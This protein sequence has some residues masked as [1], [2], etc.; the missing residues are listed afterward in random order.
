MALSDFGALVRARRSEQG[1]S[2]GDVAGRVGVSKSYMSMLESGRRAPTEKQVAQLSLALELPEDVVRVAAGQFPPDVAGLVPERIAALTAALRQQQ[3]QAVTHFATTLPAELQALLAQS[4]QRPVRAVERPFSGNQTAGKNSQAY[5]TH[6][7]HTKVPP[8]AITRLLEHYTSPNDL[9]LDPFCGS[10]MTGVAAIRAGRHAL[11]SDLSPAAVHIARN[12][13]QP[14]AP[15]ALAAAFE[16]VAVAVRPMMAWLYET[17]TSAGARQRVEY[18]VWSDVFE[19][20][21]CKEHLLYWTA[22]RDAKT[23]AVRDTVRCERCGGEHEKRALRWVAERPVES[24]ISGGAGSGRRDVHPPTRAELELMERAASTPLVHWTPQVPFLAEREMWRAGHQALGVTTVAGFY[25]PRNLHALAT[26]RHTILQ[27][28]DERLRNALL[29]AFTAILNRASKRY[30]WNVKR[31]TN[32]MTGTLYISSL[33]YEWNVWSL[34]ERKAREVLRYYEFLGTPAGRCGTVL[35]SATA[36]AHVPSQSIDFVF[37]DPPFGSNI[38]YADSSLLWDAW[39]G[40]LTDDREEIVVNKHRAPD[41]GGKTLESYRGLMTSAFAE[42][43]RVLK[44]GA[45]ATLMFNNSDDAVWV[46]IQD[47]VREAGLSVEG[48]SGLDKVHPSIKGVKGRQEKEDVASYDALIALRARPAGKAGKKG[49]AADRD[50]LREL[51]EG[52]AAAAAPASVTTDQVFAHLVRTLLERQLSVEGVSMQDV[53]ALCAEWL[54]PAAGGW[55]PAKPMAAAAPAASKPYMPVASPYGCLAEEYVGEPAALLT[56]EGLTRRPKRAAGAFEGAVEGQRNTELYNAHSY[57]TKVPPESIVP[58]LEHFTR[59]G[60]VVLDPFSGSGMTG[61]AAALAGRRAILNDLSVIGAHLAFNHT[62]PCDADALTKAFEALY[63]RL[64]PRFEQLYGLPAAGKG[65]RGYVHYTLWSRDARCPACAKEFSLWDVIDR[66]TGRMPQTLPC[67]GCAQPLKKQ[68]LRYT[69]NRPVHVSFETTSGGREERALTSSE[70]AHVEALGREDV[71]TWYPD[72]PVSADREMYVRSALHLQ[73]VHSVA[74]FYTPRNLLALGLLWEA[75]QQTPEL[76]IRQ[77]LAFAFTNTAWHGTRMRRFNARGGQRPLTGTLYI[78]QLSSEAN[79]L[80]VMRNKVKQLGAFYRAYRPAEGTPL[81]VLRIG[82]ATRLD[83]VPTASVDYIFTDP[84]FGSNIFYADCNLVWEA[85]L[86]GVTA[87]AEEAVVNRSLPKERGG[88]S[89][90]DYQGLMTQA[91]SEMHRVLKPGGWATL[92]FHNTDADVWAALQVA[93]TQA[94]FELE[95]ATGL[96]RKQQSHK[97]YKGRAGTENV[98]H[99]DVVMSMRKVARV[100][101][102]R[103]R[104]AA[105]ETTLRRLLGELKREHPECRQ[106]LQLLHSVLLQRLVREGYDLGSVSFAQVRE[107]AGLRPTG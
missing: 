33:R 61:V 62:R 107:L 97:G 105:D 90:A 66:E 72:V 43:Q 28:P 58:F 73:G 60:D 17:A 11:L 20:P 6:S 54:A 87:P 12:Y 4:A 38:F 9:V 2:L 49:R 50:T 18:T 10:G 78:P 80:E 47:A 83:G 100:E 103:A 51:I 76:R 69:A 13:T 46:A 106:S 8:E 75:I 39:L 19:C 7:Y 96:N 53:K 25:T 30:Q 65:E 71:T 34:F 22:A 82:S 16:R 41:A 48:A 26:L 14:C 37:M 1:L 27:E 95:G 101:S 42:V 23:G 29:F 88:K 74:D 89:V 91:L 55:G 98:A 31:P 102:V 35:C 85:W 104:K 3:E 94:G 81:P 40:Q 44:P 36:L 45:F 32:V 57:H 24:N 67:P 21:R 68:A 86:G 63:A 15:V 70:R 52:Y 56:P 92:V 79:V 84:P 77:A 99:F 93:A 59:P 5:R 64:R